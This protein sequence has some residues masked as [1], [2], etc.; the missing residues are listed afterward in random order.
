ME[1]DFALGWHLLGQ[2]STGQIDKQLPLHP[3]PP[4]QVRLSYDDLAGGKYESEFTI[5]VREL[6]GLGASKSPQMRIVSA[7]EA[8]AKK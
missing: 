8:M 2:E 6:R 5:D 1:F 3:V 4:F 7:L